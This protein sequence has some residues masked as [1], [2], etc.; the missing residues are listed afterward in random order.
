MR[1]GVSSATLKPSIQALNHA[2]M[3][4]LLLSLLLVTT[5][6]TSALADSPE[7]ILKDYRK[8]AA[9][10]VERLNQSLEKA[11]TPLITKLVSSGDT[12]GA[13]LLTGQ[14]KDKVAGEPV[15]KPQASAASLFSMYDEARAKALAPVQKS[16][17]ARIDS[18]LKTAGGA[19]LETVNELAK[20]RTEIEAG[21]VASGPAA[22]ESGYLAR[23]G[24]PKTWGYYLSPAY[25]KRFGTLE[26]K[27]NGTLTIEATAPVTGT[28]RKTNDPT[29]LAVDLS[30][31]ANASE[32]S[33]IVL[34][35]KEATLKRASG[36]KYLKAD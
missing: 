21:K 2:H 19:K 4:H 18:L 34:K 23:N 36:V 10:A 3:K 13:E 27:D 32:R 8:Q 12:D 26:L 31:K 1:L 11:T 6:F 17:I 33:E 22:S 15:S 28:W 9:Q 5:S 20:V 7:A 24:I 25:D 16:G 14:L 35:G 29:V 30:T